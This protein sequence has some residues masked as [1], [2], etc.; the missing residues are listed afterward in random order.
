M[1]NNFNSRCCRAIYRYIFIYKIKYWSIKIILIFLIFLLEH[2]PDRALRCKVWETN[3]IKASV[4][5]DK[6]VQTSTTLEDIRQK[7]NQEANLLGY[8]SFADLSM[9]TKMA[10]SVENVYH[11]LNTLLA[12]GKIF[13]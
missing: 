13:N 9:E 5:H 6:S 11:V 3:V 7:R 10:A 1:D 12:T 2:C 4:L 8:K